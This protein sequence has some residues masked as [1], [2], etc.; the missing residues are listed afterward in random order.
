MIQ[1]QRI[2]A[3]ALLL[4]VLL[5]TSRIAR[6]WNQTGQKHAGAFDV[7]KHFLPAHRVILW[8]L[9]LATFL[10]LA[11]RMIHA[12]LPE[13]PRPVGTIISICLCLAAFG[14]KVAFTEADSPELLIQV[15]RFPLRPLEYISLVYQARGVLFGLGLSCS[16]MLYRKA[17]HNM[18]D[19]SRKSR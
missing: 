10:F 12:G 14:F 7:A 13:V 2:S 9:V 8:V 15:M 1:D 4:T 6:G 17:Y 18:K 16:Y 19:R 3:R 11:L 5:A